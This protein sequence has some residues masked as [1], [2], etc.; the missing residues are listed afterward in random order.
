M[1]ITLTT[2]FGYQDG[3]VGVMKGVIAGINPQ[4]QVIDLSHS[5]PPHNILAGALV[6]AHSLRYF[7]R[8][9]IHLA[10]VD[11]GV[12]G[13]RQPLLIEAAGDY[14]IGPDNGILSLAFEDKLPTRILRLSNPAYH[15]QNRQNASH[16]FH[17]RDV[18]AP[19]AAHLSLGVSALAF[20]ETQDSFV[21]LA[22]PA[23]ICR[24]R[25][26]EGQIIYFDVFG[27]LFTNIRRR[28]L[29]GLGEGNPRIA[30]GQARC[31]GLVTS[32]AAIV[33]GEFGAIINSWGLLEIA[34]YKDS[35]QR[36]SG[37]KVGDKV[38]VSLKE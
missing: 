4:A 21:K 10:V 12:G 25:R 3:F 26:I 19:V 34:L 30:V 15:L 23:L 5:I 22:M 29:T 18:F 27:N 6:L 20:G 11:P 14:F 32:Y 16:T 13:T 17:G 1:I 8:G 31:E 9:T 35:A 36:R 28:D 33:P 24:E 38:E 2:D 7:P 37:A